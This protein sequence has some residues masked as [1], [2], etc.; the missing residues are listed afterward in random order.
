MD[1]KKINIGIW[2]VLFVV[3][4][5]ITVMSPRIHFGVI[6][7]LCFIQCISMILCKKER[8][9]KI[10]WKKTILGIVSIFV[11]CYLGQFLNIIYPYHAT[12]EY[13]NDIQKLKVESPQNYSHFPDVI[14]DSA[15]G[16]KWMCL[17][18]FMQGSGY[19][20]LFFYANETYIKEIYNRYA[21]IATVYT[22]SDEECT[23]IN[24]EVKNTVSFPKINEI[25]DEDKK[26]VIVMI[27]AD[28]GNL[29]HPHNSG[30]YINKVDGYVCFFAN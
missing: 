29:N 5:V 17:P 13:K 26:N 16:I 11:M 1:I 28:N 7:L 25:S 10:L 14:P 19:E 6:L 21:P 8:E 23:W 18:N 22:Y 15:T 30:L 24:N 9:K 12:Y 4:C 20:A 2:M 3:F 27:T